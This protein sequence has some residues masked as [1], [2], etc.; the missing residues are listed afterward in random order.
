MTSSTPVPRLRAVAAGAA[1]L[2]VLARLASIFLWPPDADASHAR[3]LAA[4]ALHPDRWAAA[5]AAETVAWVAAGFAVLTSVHVVT[6]RGRLFTH[7]GGWMYGASL[8]ILGL[9]GAAMNSVTGTLAGEPHRALMVGV[10][11]DL[12]SPTLSA[13]VALVMLGELCPI[14]FAVG[15]ARARLVGWWY[16]VASVLAFVGYVVTSD[17]SDHLVVLLGFVPLG[18]TW[19]A[20]GGVLAGSRR[21]DESPGTQTPAPVAQ[22]L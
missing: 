18:A 21:L 17:S 9:V 1:V 22:S 11:D 20:L 6:G 8:V 13:L 7:L 15:L 14:L 16:L 19:L 4:A 2:A 3:M 10:Q 12:G 5:T